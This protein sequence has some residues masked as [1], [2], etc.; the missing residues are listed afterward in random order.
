MTKDW[1]ETLFVW[2]GIVS[3]IEEEGKENE[4]GNGPAADASADKDGDD[5][6]A[7]K[8]TWVGC[9]SADAT[10]VPA[11]KRGAFDEFVSSPN[12]FEVE[13]VAADVATKGE[14][15]VGGR[16]LRRVAM[17]GGAGYDLGE[18]ADR[19]KHRDERHDVYFFSPGLRWRGNLRDQV[20]NVVLAVGENEFGSFVSV[21]WLRVG[22]RVTLARRY[23]NEGDERAKWGVNELWGAVSDQ[24]ATVAEDGH[25]ELAIPP[26]Q[27][28]V[29]HTD[30]GR[31]SKRQKIVEE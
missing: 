1:K 27:C 19:K 13:G 10:G 22:N 23:L 12:A 18:G 21:G 15:K 28:G 16:P 11:P 7:W 20:E 2:D 29:M 31:V 4:D 30:V 6:V 25:V 3:F 24:I 5:R 8:G 26:W 9:D 17:T 14:E